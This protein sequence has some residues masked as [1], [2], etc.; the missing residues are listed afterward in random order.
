MVIAA[1]SSE[2]RAAGMGLT[3]ARDSKPRPVALAMQAVSRQ[4]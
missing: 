4:T 2:A 3:S 1:A